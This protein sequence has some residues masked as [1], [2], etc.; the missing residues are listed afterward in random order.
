MA[1]VLCT[2]AEQTLIETRALILRRAGHT[3]WTATG[4]PELIAAC[5]QHRVEIVV[6]GQV[7]SMRQKRH[8]FDLVQQHCPGAKVLELFSPTTGR[9]LPEAD[10]WL[11]V[12][13][14]VP[15]DLAERVNAL[16]T[17]G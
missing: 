9:V 1:N 7:I 8:V 3:V 6:V 13:A 4:E 10:D 2:G 15:S 5:H 17:S 12:P 11:E 14:Q 16:A